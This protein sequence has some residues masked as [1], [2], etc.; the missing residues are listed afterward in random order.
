MKLCLY[1]ICHYNVINDP[2]NKIIKNYCFNNNKKPWYRNILIPHLRPTSR[3][4]ISGKLKNYWCLIMITRY[5]II[6]FDTFGKC[7]ASD[8]KEYLL[9]I[10][11]SWFGQQYNEKNTKIITAKMEIQKENLCGW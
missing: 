5:S 6:H 11:L 2:F 10:Q 7:D 1:M 3:N 8:L 9:N 4:I